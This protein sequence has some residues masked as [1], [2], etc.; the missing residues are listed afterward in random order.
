MC[1]KNVKNIKVVAI[2]CVLSN[3]KC[4]KSPKAVFGRGGKRKL[5]TLPRPLVSWGPPHTIVLNAFGA[6]GASISAARFLGPLK[7]KIL[8][9]SLITPL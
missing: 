2:R 4:S 9:M 5:M 1:R 6:F 8:A 7:E 3:S